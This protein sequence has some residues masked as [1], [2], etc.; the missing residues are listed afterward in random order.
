MVS[1]AVVPVSLTVSLG[2]GSAAIA[3][4][5]TSAIIGTVRI[6]PKTV[7]FFMVQPFIPS[8]ERE[9]PVRIA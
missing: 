8:K 4:P 9:G 7:I 6:V 3:V 5:A 2:A 1:P